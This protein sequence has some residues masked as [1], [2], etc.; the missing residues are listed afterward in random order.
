MITDIRRILSIF[1]KYTQL[2]IFRQLIKNRYIFMSV[3]TI[4]C[5]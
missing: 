3:T 4:T 1:F 2:K 5:S